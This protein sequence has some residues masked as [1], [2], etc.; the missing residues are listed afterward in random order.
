MEILSKLTLKESSNYVLKSL[1]LAHYLIQRK[2]AKAIINCPINKKLIQKSKKIGVT[3]FFASKCKIKDSS[4]IMFIHNKN[5]SVVPLTTH[6]DIKNVTKNI[7]QSKINK[8]MIT[9]N[10]EFKNCLNLSQK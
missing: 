9:L 8:K 10:R 3:E 7:S 1:N 6:F 5:F 4:E 2:Y